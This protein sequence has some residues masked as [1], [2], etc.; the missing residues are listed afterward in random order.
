MRIILFTI[1]LVEFVIC[2]QNFNI[3]TADQF[4]M[5]AYASYCSSAGLTQWNC[6]W[7]NY[8][9]IPSVNVQ[10]VFTNSSLNTFGYA[11]VSDE[12][13]I[14]SFRGTEILSVKNWIEDLASE[15]LVSYPAF[16]N[17][18]VG[19]GFY[20]DYLDFQTQVINA[21]QTLRNANPNLPFLFTGHSLGAAMSVLAATDVYLTLGDS[22]GDIYSWNF[23]QPRTGNS[24][25][26]NGVDSIF[27]A[28]FR[29]VNEDDIVP[30][31]PPRLGGFTHIET[32]VWFPNGY[33]NYSICTGGDGED[34]NCSDSIPVWDYSI[35]DHLE[36]LGYNF[37]DGILNGCY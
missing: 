35:P 17:A 16:Q 7:C 29:I 36:Y 21:A 15:I 1:L 9:N 26:A 24:E 30:H 32:E 22:L 23:G 14:F 33:S 27:S 5:Y 18:E 2:Q 3:G 10:Y 19:D 6:Y 13:I 34:P 4:V 11:G 8:L 20:T 12:Y 31:L 37:I 25:F 28:S